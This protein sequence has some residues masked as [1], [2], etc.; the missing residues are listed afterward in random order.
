M[1]YFVSVLK[2]YAVFS[3]RARRKEYWM[4]VLIATLISI[5]TAAIDYFIGGQLINS[6]YSLAILLPSIAVG[7]RR[8]HDT[9]RSGWWQ[10]LALI[11]IIGWILLIIFYVKEGHEDDN[12]YGS[13]PKLA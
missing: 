9:G 10:L 4:F 7:A 1:E 2:K 5:A 13:N 8:L 11:P 12:D 3:G 6:L